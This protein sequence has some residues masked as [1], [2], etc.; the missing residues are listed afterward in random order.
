M[1]LSIVSVVIDTLHET[2]RFC[3]SIRDNTKGSYELILIDNG[4]KKKKVREFIRKSSDVSYRFDIQT[5]LAAAWNK[6]IALAKGKY[7]AIANNDIVVPPDWFSP[8]K[9]IFEKDRKAGMV[10][11]LTYW[12]LRHNLKYRRLKS[13]DATFRIPRWRQGVWGECNVLPRRVLKEIGGF[14]EEYKIA[15][16]EDLEM[17]YEL[18]KRDYHVIIEPRVFVFH[19]GG[20]TANKIYSDKERKRIWEK[21]WRLFLKRWESKKK[22]IMEWV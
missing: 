22:Y 21:N 11:P 3:S 2:E 19:Q 15:S 14:C 9:R 13:L 12:I 5:D 7:I 17:L 10:S 16:G 18:H 4:S 6:G 1:D 8:L 20:A